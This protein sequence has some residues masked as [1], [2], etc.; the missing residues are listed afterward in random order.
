[1]Q[2][3]G[4]HAKTAM[5]DALEHAL[6]RQAGE[7]LAHR[8]AAHAECLADLLLADEFTRRIQAAPDARTQR[9]VDVIRQRLGAY[10]RPGLCQS[11]SSCTR[12][13][14]GS[15]AIRCFIYLGRA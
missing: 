9:V 12:Y 2:R 13:A 15:K 5:R 3:L 11:G 1:T 6:A 4:G 8:R 14:D 7:G 10:D